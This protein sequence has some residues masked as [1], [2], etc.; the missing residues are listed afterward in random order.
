VD[1][2]A[3]RVEDEAEERVEADD[4][5]AYARKKSIDAGITKYTLRKAMASAPALVTTSVS[6]VS[7]A[8]VKM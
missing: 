7:R 3:E 2:L 6:L 1:A 5:F 4:I 8:I